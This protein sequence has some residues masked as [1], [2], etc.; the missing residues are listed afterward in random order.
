MAALTRSA[1]QVQSTPDTTSP[2]SLAAIAAIAFDS[3]P[4]CPS[5]PLSHRHNDHTNCMDKDGGRGRV[6][7]RPTSAFRPYGISYLLVHA[8]GF[9]LGL[10]PSMF[11]NA[12]T[13]VNEIGRR[14]HVRTT[15]AVASCRLGGAVPCAT[16]HHQR[17]PEASPLPR[18]PSALSP[19]G[20]SYATPPAPLS[21]P[22]NLSA[23]ASTFVA[24]ETWPAGESAVPALPPPLPGMQATRSASQQSEFRARSSGGVSARRSTI[25]FSHTWLAKLNS[26]GPA[27]GIAAA[28]ASQP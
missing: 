7:V 1:V 11:L 10:I 17:S 6:T 13:C 25:T 15:Y 26:D 8:P 22:T 16:V 3:S 21:V 4:R 19:A 27:D 12:S 20:T 18:S 2:T 28:A 24:D 5:S 23:A 9:P 14:G